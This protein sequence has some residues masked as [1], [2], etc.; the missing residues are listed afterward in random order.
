MQ[1]TLTSRETDPHD[2]FAIEPE[3]IPAARAARAPSDLVHDILSRPSAP[4]AY[5]ASAGAPSPSVDTTF[6]ATDVN[7][8]HVSDI[9]VD[10]IHLPRNRP[11]TGRW[12]KRVF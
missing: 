8:L 2:I 10:D 1:S 11:S 5:A 4:R 7:D 9:Q 6:R 12:A 3:A